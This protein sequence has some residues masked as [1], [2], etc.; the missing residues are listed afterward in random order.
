MGWREDWG[1]GHGDREVGA[2]VGTVGGDAGRSGGAEGRRADACSRISQR[3]SAGRY[4]PSSPRP[5]TWRPRPIPARP[6]PLPPGRQGAERVS[7][8]RGRSAAL[9]LSLWTRR[10][11]HGAGFESRGPGFL[12][13]RCLTLALHD[14]SREP[15][16]DLLGVTPPPH[17]YAKVHPIS[18]D[19]PQS[20]R[21]LVLSIINAISTFR[22]LID[23]HSPPHEVL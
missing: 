7:R 9:C 13:H 19:D 22:L 1:V 8:R 11:H 23:P 2:G 20:V 10:P 18:A 6:I 16:R 4:P 15:L 21:R 5:W 3:L 17:A 14:V 12:T